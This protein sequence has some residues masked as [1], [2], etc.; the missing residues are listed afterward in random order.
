VIAPD[1]KART[2]R[3]GLRPTGGGFGTPPFEDGSR[4]VVQG[5]RLARDPG[6][7]AP[8]TNLRDAAAFLGLALSDDPG[9]GQDL[10]PFAPDADLRV[11]AGASTALGAWYAFGNGALERLTDAATAGDEAVAVTEAQL[12]PEH[13]DLAVTAELAGGQKVNVGFSPGDAYSTE[14]YLYV[15]PHDTAALDE[16][17]WNAPF[18]AVLEYEELRRQA[19]PAAAADA[20]IARGLALAA[21]PGGSSAA[22]NR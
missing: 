2:G 10:P 19:D 12:W 4:V 11:D 20:F 15:G 8:I 17:F 13:F 18:G 14:P 5:D 21:R 16:P 1:R 6:A 3:I 22:P 7:A 9:V